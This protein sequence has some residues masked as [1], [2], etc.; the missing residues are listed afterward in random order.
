MTQ[1]FDR[2]LVSIPAKKWA[3]LRDDPNYRLVR[4][5]DNGAIRVDVEWLGELRDPFETFPEFYKLF[6][7]NVWNYD[8]ANQLRRDPVEDGK[9]FPTEELAVQAYELFLERWTS[10]HRGE[11][12]EFIEEGNELAPPPPPAP[13]TPMTDVSEIKSTKLGDDDVGVW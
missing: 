1:Y 11:R 8:A 12:G 9:T 2:K 10:S 4:A 13:D 6:R 3:A 5:Y 7:L